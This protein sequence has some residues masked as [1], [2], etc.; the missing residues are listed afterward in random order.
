MA[1]MDPDYP[2]KREA[3]FREWSPSIHYAQF[4]RMATGA[5][6][7]AGYMISSCSMYAMGKPLPRCTGT[8][9]SSKQAS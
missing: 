7:S 6:R 1:E 5:L 4:Q 8:G 9:M 3:P 2:V